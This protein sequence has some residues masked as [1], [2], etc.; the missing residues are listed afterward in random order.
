MK[1]RQWHKQILTSSPLEPSIL[2][3]VGIT[4]LSGYRADLCHSLRLC[5]L[6][7]HSDLTTSFAGGK[8][9]SHVP[10]Q[11]TGC[12]INRG[13]TREPN[14]TESQLAELRTVPLA[15]SL[16]PPPQ[17]GLD[18]ESKGVRPLV[19]DSSG[20]FSLVWRPPSVPGA[21]LSSGRQGDCR[22]PSSC[23]GLRGLPVGRGGVMLQ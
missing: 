21:V 19:W 18:S 1:A 8:W 16:Q 14:A 4:Y 12:H 23:L 17:R 5:H 2:W 22:C 15:G 3:E 6:W 7:D 20:W 10:A 9:G 11:G 13:F